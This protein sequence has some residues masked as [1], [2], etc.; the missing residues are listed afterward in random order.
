[1]AVTLFAT[2]SNG[3]ADLTHTVM[4]WDQEAHHHHDSGE[5]HPE[6]S[7]ESAQ[8]LMADYSNAAAVLS[9]AGSYYFRPG[10]MSSAALPEHPGPNPFLEGLLRPPRPIV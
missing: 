4:H 9:V 7:D 5:Y 6:D 1:M 10:V 8:H 2:S 3:F